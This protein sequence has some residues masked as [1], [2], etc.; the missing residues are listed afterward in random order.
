[1]VWLVGW[2]ESGMLVGWC[3]GGMVGDDSLNA[4][5][6]PH[7]LLNNTSAGW[8]MTAA[9][10]PDRYDRVRGNDRGRGRGR[11]RGG[12]DYGEGWVGGRVLLAA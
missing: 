2:C 9:S 5:A 8:D 11:I 3:E 6:P 4:F 12:S 7:T 1:M 10:T